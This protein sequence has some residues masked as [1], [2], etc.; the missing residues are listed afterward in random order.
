M[1]TDVV[2][3]LGQIF[4]SKVVL[5]SAFVFQHIAYVGLTV[6]VSRWFVGLTLGKHC[7]LVLCRLIIVCWY[8]VC[9]SL[10]L[11]NKLLIR[12]SKV[13]ILIN[14]LM[15]ISSECTMS[16]WWS[17]VDKSWIKKRNSDYYLIRSLRWHK[18]KLDGGH[19]LTWYFQVCAKEVYIL[20]T[21]DGY[22]LIFGIII[23]WFIIGFH[24]LNF[25][26]MKKKI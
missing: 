8:Y 16:Y 20:L 25:L 9:L 11:E 21:Y 2:Q 13:I 22:N 18:T 14:W 26:S 6:D 4:Y 5:N 3:S 7:L 12:C 10:D 1:F 24:F 17:H 19:I 15:F 23:R